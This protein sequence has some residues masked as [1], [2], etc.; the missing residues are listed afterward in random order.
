MLKVHGRCTGG[1]QKV[2]GR[3][4]EG[5]WKIHGRCMG[6]VH[7]VCGR[8]HVDF[9]KRWWGQKDWVANTNH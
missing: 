4:A 9:F 7:K 2:P 5:A 6:G 3:F 1:A 8:L